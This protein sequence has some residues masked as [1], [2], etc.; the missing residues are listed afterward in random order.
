MVVMLRVIMWRWLMERMIVI[1]VNFGT[2]EMEVDDVEDDEVK[3]TG[4]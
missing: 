1:D 3:E 4:R 2:D